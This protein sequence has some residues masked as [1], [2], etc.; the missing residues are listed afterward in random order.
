[1]IRKQL[2][3]GLK[4]KFEVFSSKVLKWDLRKIQEYRVPPLQTKFV[5]YLEQKE[6]LP[7]SPRSNNSND[8]L[9]AFDIF[10]FQRVLAR[11]D[12][13]RREDFLPVKDSSLQSFLFHKENISNIILLYK[14]NFRFR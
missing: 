2:K 13:P 7:C 14:E 1:M 4:E 11:N 6:S 12:L 5:H 10:P 8:L 9:Q 3:I